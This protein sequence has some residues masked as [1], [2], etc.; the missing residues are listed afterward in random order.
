[1]DPLHHAGAGGEELGVVVVGAVDHLAEI[2][3]SGEGRAFSP[4]HH[5]P[6]FAGHRLE[7]LDQ[8]LQHLEAERIALLGAGQ[9]DGGDAVVDFETDSVELHGSQ[10]T[11]RSPPPPR[12]SP[13]QVLP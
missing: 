6:G 13:P 5:H 10:L 4:Q 11:R 1:M 9:G 2:V 8:R 3:A 7:G 12:G